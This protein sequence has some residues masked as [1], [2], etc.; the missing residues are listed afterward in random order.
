MRGVTK[1]LFWSLILLVY[2]GHAYAQPKIP[3]SWTYT[4]TTIDEP[5]YDSYLGNS[6]PPNKNQYHYAWGKAVYHK[7]QNLDR[8]VY[9]TLVV[10]IEY[11]CTDKDSTFRTLREIRYSPT[12]QVISDVKLHGKLAKLDWNVHDLG[13]LSVNEALAYNAQDLDNSCFGGIED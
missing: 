5:I 4:S 12:G 2:A 8:G 3:T 7:P 10:L 13:L 6:G 11:T 9:K 1:I